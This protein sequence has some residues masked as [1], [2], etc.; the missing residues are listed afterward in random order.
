MLNNLIAG[1]TGGPSEIKNPVLE[2]LN[3]NGT[4][5]GFFQKFIPNAITLGFVIGILIFFFLLL[6]GAIQWISSGGDKQSLEGA[7]NKLSSAIIGIV[8]LLVVF[9]IIRLVGDFFGINLLDLT[10]PTLVE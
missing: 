6:I 8:I 9:A 1:A 2:G 3:E 4:G 5:L 10:L 7:R